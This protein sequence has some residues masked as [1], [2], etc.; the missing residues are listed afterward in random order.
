MFLLVVYVFAVST[1][2]IF[3]PNHT[4]AGPSAS[5]G[6]VAVVSKISNAGASGNFYIKQHGA[7]KTTNQNT[8]KTIANL[9]NIAIAV[10]LV[11]ACGFFKS[12]FANKSKTA[13]VN[14]VRL[15]YNSCVVLCTFRI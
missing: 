3:L 8:R 13:P 1:Y 5:V 10:S 9:F 12:L 7:F 2:I 11:A 4:A 14:E 6:G 15:H